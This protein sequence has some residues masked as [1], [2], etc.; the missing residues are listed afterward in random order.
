[1]KEQKGVNKF[2]LRNDVFFIVTLLLIA[3]VGMVY[4]FVFREPGEVVEVSI[5]GEFYGRYSLSQ[6]IT[7][8]IPSEAGLNR[9]VISDGRAMM[10]SATCPDGVCVSHRPVFR[11]RESIVCLPNRVVVVTVVNDNGVDN[12]APDV[13]A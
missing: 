3:L 5:D 9:L 7:V 8:D 4:L 2:H 1:M 11:S 13:V 10:E 6:N 12:D